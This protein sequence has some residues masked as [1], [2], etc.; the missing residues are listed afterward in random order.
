MEMFFS[1]FYP[2]FAKNIENFTK[3]YME[4]RSFNSNHVSINRFKN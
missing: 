3:C 4:K 1:T 2:N